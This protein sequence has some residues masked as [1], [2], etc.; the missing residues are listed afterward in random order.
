MNFDEIIEK[1][2]AGTIRTELQKEMFA[3]EGLLPMWVADMDFRSPSCITDAL[4]DTL[5]ND[6]LGYH[7]PPDAFYQ[8]V[9]KWQGEKHGMHLSREDIKY[10]PGVVTGIAVA[11]NAFTEENDKIVVQTP[12]YFPFFEYPRK[13]KRQ[14]V[15]NSLIEKDAY[16]EMDYEDLERHFA[17]GAKMLILCSPHNPAGRVWRRDELEK[18]AALA[19]KYKVIVVADEI[20]S[21]MPLGGREVVSYATVSEAAANHSLTLTAPSKTFNI[22]GLA[23]SIAIIQ[24]EDLRQKW[25]A[26]AEAYE[27]NMGDFLGYVA[28]TAAFEKGDKWRVAL[29]DYLDANVQFTLDFF[30]QHIPQIKAWEPEASFL[31]WLDCRAMGMSD[32]QLMKFF[33]DKAGLLLSPGIKFGREARGFMRMNFAMPRPLLEKALMQLKEAF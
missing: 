5:D 26:V 30:K 13:N 32:A 7:V 12:V 22:A 15:Y 20:H 24:N 11:I 29:L 14:V 8:S 31:M 4:K 9:I 33:T 6:I 21:D 3:C 1:R 27:L 2:G 17:D 10:V 16:Y 25:V 19:D 23:S 28:L 18:V